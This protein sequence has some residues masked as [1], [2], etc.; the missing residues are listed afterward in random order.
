MTR[1]LIAAFVCA[2]TPLLAGTAIFLAWLWL[3]WESLEDAGGATILGGLVLFLVGSVCLFMHVRARCMWQFQAAPLLAAT[4]LF[5]N[6]PVALACVRMAS[7]IESRYYVTVENSSEHTIES[8]TVT[9]SGVHVEF[10][11]IAPDTTVQHWFHLVRDEHLAYRT[12]FD[13]VDQSGIIEGYV[14]KESGGRKHILIRSD[15]TIE[16]SDDERR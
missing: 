3:G 9:G 14:I 12:R 15:Y 2:L 10:G 16:V 7:S 11:P 4:L 6:F 13:A 5:A 1:W 8:F